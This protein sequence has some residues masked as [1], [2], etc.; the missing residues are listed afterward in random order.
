MKTQRSKMQSQRVTINQKLTKQLRLRAGAE[1]L[2]NAST[3]SKVKETV[4]LELS[5]LNSNLQLLKEELSSINSSVEPYQSSSGKTVNI[6]MIP[7]GL[8]DTN[9][10]DF[11]DRFSEIFSEHYGEDPSLYSDEIADLCDLRNAIRTPARNQHGVSLLLEYYN[12][13]YFIEHRFYF[14]IQPQYAIYFHWY[15]SLTGI[16]SLQRSISLE[17]AC[18]LFNVASLYSQIA[19]KCDRTRR[20]GI[21]MALEYFQRAA[22]AYNYLRLN[23]SNA[24]THDLSHTF[25]S[26]ATKLMLAQAQEC[27]YENLVFGGF[28]IQLGKCVNIAKEA[29]KVSEKYTASM[30][31]LTIKDV[32]SFVPYIWINMCEVKSLYYRALAH[33]YTAMGLLKQNEAAEPTEITNLISA[34]YVNVHDEPQVDDLARRKEDRKRLGKAHLRE[35][36]NIHVDSLETFK[37]C[38]HER[39]NDV[40]EQYLQHAHS[41]TTNKLAEYDQD[42][43]FFE[44]TETPTIQAATSHNSECIPPSFKDAPVVDIFKR[45]GPLTVFSSKVKLGAHRL[46]DF[47]PLDLDRVDIKLKGDSPVR[48]SS[49]AQRLQTLGMCEDDV[50]I[51]V[52]DEDVRWK[53]RNYVTKLMTSNND[54]DLKLRLVSQLGSISMTSPTAGYGQNQSAENF[55]REGEV[56]QHNNNNNNNKLNHVQQTM[57]NRSKNQ[58]RT[59]KTSKR[60]ENS[61]RNSIGFFPRI[62]RDPF[63]TLATTSEVKSSSKHQNNNNASAANGVKRRPSILGTLRR[64]GSQI[65]FGS[66]AGQSKNS[67][68]KKSSKSNGHAF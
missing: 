65:L 10:I 51:A 11:S 63:N 64:S 47:S 6:P 7:L 20:K 41:R 23:F 27:I 26:S 52:G 67:S 9:S 25:L 58:V 68:Q 19:C 3:N 50:I 29:M 45:L 34:L 49:V 54:D 28:E 5:F 24:P 48:I 43:D 53:D 14:P 42:N 15:D 12:Q 37:L 36:K 38:K 39:A 46:V 32:S 8:K 62:L 31:D 40:L 4:A 21:E 57:P 18:V 13:L 22:G 30:K 16:P 44:L 59:R 1:N 66:S 33:Y 55:L 2:F 56:I 61:H 17:K 35:A 60:T